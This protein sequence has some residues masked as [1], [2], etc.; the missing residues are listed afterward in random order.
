MAETSPSFTVTMN[1]GR[2]PNQSSPFLSRPASDMTWTDGKQTIKYTATAEMLPLHRR[3][4]AH[5]AHI[6]PLPRK[7]CGRS[8]IAPSPSAGTAARAALSAMVNIGGL[9]PRRVPINTIKQ[10]PCPTKPEDNPTRFCPKRPTWCAWTPWAPAT[11][12]WRGYDPK[13]VWGVDGDADAFMRG[14]AQWLT[15]HERWEHASVPVRR[16]LRHHAQLGTHARA[17]QARHRADRRHRAVHHSRLRA[18]ASGNDLYYMG[19]LPVYAATANYFGKAGAGVDQFRV[20]RP[21]L[22]VRR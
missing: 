2:A 11:R 6:R 8:P 1:D 12:R 22:E 4:H 14:I 7:R 3:R 17:R 21:R 10:L 9:G 15:T 5:R 18:D 13:K 19:M 16:V 20:V